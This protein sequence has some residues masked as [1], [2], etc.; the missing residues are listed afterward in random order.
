MWYSIEFESQSTSPNISQVPERAG[1]QGYDLQGDCMVRTMQQGPDGCP[2][3]NKIR[4]ALII[5]ARYKT[6][7]HWSVATVHPPYICG[8]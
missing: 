7:P 6:S 1:L 5:R 8:I 3:I 2:C 4:E